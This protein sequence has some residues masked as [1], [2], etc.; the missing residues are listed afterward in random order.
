MFIE[1]WETPMSKQQTTKGFTIIEVVLVLAIA[2]LI[3]LMVFIALPALQSGQRDSARKS[4]AST[5]LSAVNTYVAGNRGNFPTT[6]QLTGSTNAGGDH[7]TAF[8]KP[9]NFAKDVSSNTEGVRVQTAGTLT[10]AVKVGE[11]V[12]TQSTTCGSTGTQNSSN[13]ATQTLVKGTK[14]QY[15]VTTFLEGGGGVSYCAQS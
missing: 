10:A 3:F 15:T 13:V 14:N 11:I 5:I 4:D 7:D 9:S 6:A 8:K 2:G 12:V 1:R